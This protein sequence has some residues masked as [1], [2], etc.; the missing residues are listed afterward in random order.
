[1]RMENK[2]WIW[3]QVSDTCAL[4]VGVPR[5]GVGSALSQA[6][7]WKT[8][9]LTLSSTPLPTPHTLRM[10]APRV[11]G[12]QCM[13]LTS[14][15]DKYCKQVG[16]EEPKIAWETNDPFAG[17]MG[18]MPGLFRQ[19]RQVFSPNSKLVSHG[20]EQLQNISTG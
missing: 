6:V 7:F 2:V 10:P 19:T 9:L 13:K 5:I 15:N 20:R 3:T 17:R 1:M 14:C 8:G 12:L 16:A 18:L 11:W 4:G